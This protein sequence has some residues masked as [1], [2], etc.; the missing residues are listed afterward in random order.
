MAGR[1]PA[2]AARFCRL[3]PPTPL[4]VQTLARPLARGFGSAPVQPSGA[5][6]PGQ[7]TTQKYRDMTPAQRRDYLTL[8]HGLPSNSL[9]IIGGEGKFQTQLVIGVGKMPICLIE[10]VPVCFVT[11]NGT[12]T[13]TKLLGIPHSLPEGSI[14]AGMK[15]C[16]DAVRNAG[17][18]FEVTPAKSLMYS[19][20]QLVFKTGISETQIQA[21]ADAI[22]S[23]EQALLHEVNTHPALVNMFNRGGGALKLEVRI[24][25]PPDPSACYMA[26]VQA[27]AD[28][29]QAQGANYLT[30][31][32]HVLAV[33]LQKMVAPNA[34]TLTRIL[35][36][37]GGLRVTTCSVAFP[38][39]ALATKHV[40]AAEMQ[41][42]IPL[43]IE[44]AYRD[45][46]IRGCTAR[47]G[48]DK[49]GGLGVVNAIGEDVPAYVAGLE[50]HDTRVQATPLENG[51]IRFRLAQ[52]TVAGLVSRQHYE[53]ASI[54]F[55][56]CGIKTI[57]DLYAV[58]SI[59]SMCTAIMAPRALADDIGITGHHE[60]RF[61]PPK[62]KTTSTGSAK[63]E[64]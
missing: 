5:D 25:P 22:L 32:A 17:R 51:D 11:P 10:D 7:I 24:L 33:P 64:S 29:C 35:S 36:N 26:V 56:L 62:S 6:T 40:C 12:Q 60:D 2:T 43:V 14:P 3:I 16:V 8:K 61:V 52:P 37:Y 63:T 44:Y 55:A 41:R 1:L 58:I 31:L 23:Q 59:A 9:D 18:H 53:H 47:K 20:V 38:G 39:A 49:N 50:S 4:T 13:T 34:E 27:T 46:V 48:G 21:T 45:P 15:Y 19:T 42:R 28:V 54:L 30:R 57:P